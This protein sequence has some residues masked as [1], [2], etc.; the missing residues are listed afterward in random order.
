MNN[1]SHS[2]SIKTTLKSLSV[3]LV[4]LLQFNN[5]AHCQKK[6]SFQSLHDGLSNYHIK[7]I[8]QDSKG[9]MW[10]GTQDG[11]NKFDGNHFRNYEN[12]VS[13]SNSISNNNINAIIEDKYRNSYVTIFFPELH[14]TLMNRISYGL[15]HP[16]MD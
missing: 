16:G 13:D 7:C 2:M 5:W 4:L 10:F 9:F 8:F 14:C 15:E 11:L 6:I 12:S 3:L 1:Y